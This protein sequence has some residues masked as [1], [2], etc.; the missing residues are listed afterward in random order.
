MD[1][2]KKECIYATEGDRRYEIFQTCKLL[3]KEWLRWYNTDYIKNEDNLKA[4]FDY[5]MNFDISEYIPN[6]DYYRGKEIEDIERIGTFDQFLKKT[7][8]DWNE[9]KYR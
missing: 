7:I 8:T 2:N 5:I 3:S 6:R 1:T 9:T 4:I